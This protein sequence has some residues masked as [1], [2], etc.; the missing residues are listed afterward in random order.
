M[1]CSSSEGEESSSCV[2]KRFVPTAWEPGVD[3]YYEEH[4]VDKDCHNA[5]CKNIRKPYIKNNKHCYP[6]LK[7]TVIKACEVDSCLV[8]TKCIKSRGAEIDDLNVKGRI[9]LNGRD[10]DNK[11][12]SVILANYIGLIEGIPERPQDPLILPPAIPIPRGVFSPISGIELPY[13]ISLY[14]IMGR[15]EIRNLSELKQLYSKITLINESGEPRRIAFVLFI[16]SSNGLPVKENV[17]ERSFIMHSLDIDIQTM[18]PGSIVTFNVN[19]NSWR[20]SLNVIKDAR[21]VAI[22]TSVMPIE[23]PSDLAFL[24]TFKF[25]AESLTLR[26]YAIYSDYCVKECKECSDEE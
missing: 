26:I 14:H 9:I 5:G 4:R 15:Q 11:E 3:G 16:Y 21:E 24:K 20:S 10:I 12:D 2:K 1:S 25:G 6:R 13:Y 18:I 23:N 22:F 8:K 7:T 19:W 17:P